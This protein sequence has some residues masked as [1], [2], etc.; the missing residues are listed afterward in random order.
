MMKMWL[1]LIPDLTQIHAASRKK[2][3]AQAGKS[4][5]LPAELIVIAVWL[6]VVFLIT[7][8]ILAGATDENR[9]AF[10][11]VANFVVTIPLLLAVFLPIHIR[12]IRRDIRRQLEY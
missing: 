1:F 5:L 11:L 9:L 8:S 6:V 4:G 12:R 2:A 7:K 10:T 3:L